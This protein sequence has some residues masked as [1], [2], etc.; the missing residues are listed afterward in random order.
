[1]GNLINA[2]F[3]PQN[4][5]LPTLGSKTKN[6]TFLP[7]FGPFLTIFRHFSSFLAFFSVFYLKK[8]SLLST[9][10]FSVSFVLQ[11]SWFWL[12]I[13]LFCPNLSYKKCFK[14]HVF[15]EIHLNVDFQQ[16]VFY[17]FY[18]TTIFRGLRKTSLSRVRLLYATE[19]HP[20]GALA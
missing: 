12:K 10:A 7:F 9:F 13:D 19:N 16:T 20:C 17:V 1:V 3:S 8:V 6:T 15:L 5:V 14:K 4:P 2:L 11:F 18:E